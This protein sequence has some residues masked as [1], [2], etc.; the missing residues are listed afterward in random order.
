MMES[1]RWPMAAG[2]SKKKPSASGPRWAM[3]RAARR[4]AS[5]SG[6][7]PKETSPQMPHMLLAHRAGQGLHHGRVELLR[8]Q[9]R[10]LVL[11]LVIGADH[12]LGEKPHQDRE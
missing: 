12:E 6:A 2:P 7:A 9:V 3:E 11:R 5:A 1:R 8:H 4:T 10:P